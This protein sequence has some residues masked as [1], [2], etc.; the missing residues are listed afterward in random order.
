[1]SYQ[2]GTALDFM[3]RLHQFASGVDLVTY[4]TEGKSYIGQTGA[5]GTLYVTSGT[6]TQWNQEF[7]VKVYRESGVSPTTSYF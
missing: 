4:Q 7:G 6:L 3:T 5:D 1:M 2:T